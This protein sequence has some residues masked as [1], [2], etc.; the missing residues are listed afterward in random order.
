MGGAIRTTSAFENIADHRCVRQFEQ[1]AVSPSKSDRM[2]LRWLMKN[3][4]S[5]QQSI[6]QP[7]PSGAY[8]VA[9]A[10]FACRKSWKIE[11]RE[12]DEANCPDCGG[13]IRWMGRNFKAPKKRD[14][15][16]WKKVEA[17]WNGGVR[18]QSQNLSDPPP[19]DL[20]D[21]EEYLKRR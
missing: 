5:D 10:C 15:E 3:L 11:P 21:V 19:S 16:Q 18:F 12:N 8:L 17:L 14:I 9:H 20:R 4:R 7:R 2:E 13:V 1:M 6:P